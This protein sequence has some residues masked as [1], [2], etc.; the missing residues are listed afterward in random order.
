MSCSVA[1]AFIF[2]FTACTK[3]V[4]QDFAVFRT[5]VGEQIWYHLQDPNLL[6]GGSES[7]CAQ[8]ALTDFYKRRNYRE[9]WT[10]PQANS[11]VEVLSRAEMEGLRPQD[12][13]LSSIEKLLALLRTDIQKG[14]VVAPDQLANLD[15]LLTDAFLIYGSHLLFGRVNPESI[16]PM[17]VAH[18]PN[19]DL[20]A[21]LETAI[22]S[23]NIAGTLAKLEP[24]QI[25]Y[26]R[27]CEA[28]M[29]HQELA[30]RGGW[31]TISDGPFLKR[32]DHGPRVA[33]LRKRLILGR[34]LDATTWKDP[35]MFNE[36]LEQAVKRFQLRH[37]LKPNGTMDAATRAELNV[38]VKRR[39][40]QLEL[41]LE[42]WRWLPQDLGRCYILVNIPAFKLE[43]VENGASVLAMRV[44]V[45]TIN[46]PTPILNA[47][48]EY[49]FL[50]PYWNVP[51]DMVV[52]EMLPRIKSDPSY[53]TRKNYRVFDGLGPEAREVDPQT[54][55]WS[56]ITPDNF[57]YRLRQ[58]PGPFNGMGHV[59]FI[60]TNKFNVYLHDTP[61]RHLFEKTPRAFS[62]GCIR[63][64][65]PID[66]AVYLLGKDPQWNRDA[67][68][69]KLNEKVTHTV[70]LPEKLPI[71]LV[72][73][74]VWA[75]LDG[76][77]QFRPDIYG[78]DALL[79][80]A[81]R[82]PLSTKEVVDT[83]NVTKHKGS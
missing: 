21:V 35:Q 82:A 14:L 65:Q 83:R 3:R 66:L 61:G 1:L 2:F 57:P 60:F 13:H 68:L 16:Q 27:L 24:V 49:L 37:G 78:W 11:L 25:G 71:Y 76:T 67:L 8:E 22:E 56:T 32:G 7:I 40:E 36:G 64:E 39:I 28:L 52:K 44:V 42:R 5:P 79:L 74:T 17:W 47:T 55:D 69:R 26:R 75:D 31:P 50:N 46:D 77:I 45:G 53:L 63:I 62:H 18:Q 15:L 29:Y 19:V 41:N 81:I 43:V 48:M 70:L 12:Y 59:K 73:W 4:D 34:D 10:I 72:Y 80:G 38:S 58:E 51:R 33:A 54:I 23:D 6:S 20:A 9:A 30:S